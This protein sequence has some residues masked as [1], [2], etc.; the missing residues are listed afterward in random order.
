MSAFAGVFRAI[1]RSPACKFR[2]ATYRTFECLNLE[3][4]LHVHLLEFQHL[5]AYLL[6]DPESRVTSHESRPC[7]SSAIER[8]RGCAESGLCGEQAVPRAGTPC[9]AR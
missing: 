6:Q 2:H 5:S 9:T 1:V 4:A 8:Q 3:A 7:S